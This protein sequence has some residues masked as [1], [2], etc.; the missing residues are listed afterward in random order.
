MAGAVNTCKIGVFTENGGDG[1]WV[2]KGEW[3]GKHVV[4]QKKVDYPGAALRNISIFTISAYYSARKFER[5]LISQSCA[6]TAKD[7]RVVAIIPY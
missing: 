2:N 6:E 3:E 7:Y 1:E 4:I 5:C